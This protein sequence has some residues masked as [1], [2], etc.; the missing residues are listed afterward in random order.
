MHHSKEWFSPPQPRFCVQNLLT[1]VAAGAILCEY[2]PNDG[3]QWPLPNVAHAAWG[4]A[5]RVRPTLGRDALALDQTNPLNPCVIA[6]ML[7]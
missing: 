5:C 4:D 6:E 1:P 2:L 3:V 7:L